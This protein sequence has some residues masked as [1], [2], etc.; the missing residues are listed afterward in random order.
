VSCDVPGGARSI[1]AFDRVDAEG[2]VAP[3]VDDM[4]IDDALDEIG[5]GGVRR[6]RVYVRTLG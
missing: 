2:Q 4:G 3:A 5:P 6:G 1:G